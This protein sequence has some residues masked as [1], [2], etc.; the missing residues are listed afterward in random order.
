MPYGYGDRLSLLVFSHKCPNN[1]P[2]ILWSSGREWK[3][4][5]P[6]NP[7]AGTTPWEQIA[8]ST[9]RR[10][11]AL[12]AILSRGADETPPSSYFEPE[13]QLLLLV[14]SLCRRRRRRVAIIADIAEVSTATI[15]AAL[16]RLQALGWLDVERRVTDAGYAQLE[17]ARR[18]GKPK[19]ERP[20]LR[21]DFYY[22]KTLRRAQWLI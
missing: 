16:A 6:P 3:P 18:L 20:L 9:D 15:E 12:D 22:P 7:A 8:N 1:A 11:A 13:A 17:H 2:P 14:L 21:G 10:L 19:S 4:V 5:F